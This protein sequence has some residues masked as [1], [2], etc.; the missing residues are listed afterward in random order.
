[1]IQRRAAGAAM[2]YLVLAAISIG[3]ELNIRLYHTGTSEFAGML[4]TVVT[5]P[6]SLIVF[7][8]AKILAHAQ[9]GDS[10]AIFVLTLGLA[11]ALN[12]ALIYALARRL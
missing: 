4:S 2:T 10:N 5:L 7:Y 3:Y 12:A 8:L 6:A 1:M 9:P 11:A